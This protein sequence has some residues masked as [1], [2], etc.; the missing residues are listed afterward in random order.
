MKTP[1]RMALANYL[2][3]A[4]IDIREREEE[5]ERI[6]RSAG[7]RGDMSAEEMKSLSAQVFHS[8]RHLANTFVMLASYLE[9]EDRASQK[10]RRRDRLKGRLQKSIAALLKP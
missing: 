4:A 3:T 5:I 2:I 8:H 9:E 6:H 1:S 10:G 7:K